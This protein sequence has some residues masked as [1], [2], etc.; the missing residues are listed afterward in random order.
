MEF[1]LKICQKF[2]GCFFAI[3]L[4]SSIIYPAYAVQNTISDPNLQIILNNPDTVKQGKNFTL[5]SIVKA[6][7]DQITNVTV[8]ISSPE[9]DIT[10]NKFHLDKLAKDST[11]GNDF[12]AKVKND[13]PDGAFVA[14]LQ[15]DYFVKGY[16]DSQPV[17]HSIAQA[18]QLVAE[19]K[20]ILVF[21]IQTQ[22][23]VFSGEPFSVKGTIV[24]QGANAQN[25]DISLFSTTINLEGKKALSIS[26]L[27]SG[28]IAQFEFVVQTPKE[29]GVPTHAI[30][31]VN[32]TYSDE[33]GKSYTIDN[34]FSTFARQRG[35]LEVGDADGIWVGDFFIA[36]VVG[37]GTIVSSAIGFMMFLWH[38]KNKKKSKKVKR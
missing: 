26:E 37:V 5:S 14:N 29:L 23:N 16:F 6:T 11:F 18:I 22:T 32:G 3:A 38:Y 8:T 27:D 9:L 35:I 12:E 25:I 19:S 13:T 30:L 4:I 20:P 24:N 17:K 28:K 7:A 36:P 1:G 21:N 15:L 34:S 2:L 33:S 10:Q 31:H